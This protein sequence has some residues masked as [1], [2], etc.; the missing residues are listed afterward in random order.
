[1]SRSS[2]AGRFK[3]YVLAESS[4]DWKRRGSPKDD[5]YGLFFASSIARNR[6]NAQ[7]WLQC[8]NRTTK[9]VFVDESAA[10]DAAGKDENKHLRLYSFPDIYR[11]ANPL[12]DSSVYRGA[13]HAMQQSMRD[14]LTTVESMEAPV[15]L[16]SDHRI[17]RVRKKSIKKSTMQQNAKS[18][19]PAKTPRSNQK[20]K[21]G[22]ST[23]A[24]ATNAND[25]VPNPTRIFEEPRGRQLMRSQRSA[26]Q[27]PATKLTATQG[28]VSVSS[29]AISSQA[30]KPRNSTNAT[31]ATQSIAT[32]T[33]LTND[34]EDALFRQ[35]W[36]DN[37]LSDA[38]DTLDQQGID[39]QRRRE[40]DNDKRQKEIDEQWRLWKQKY[41]DLQA[42]RLAREQ[43]RLRV[44]DDRK[45]RRQQQLEEVAEQRRKEEERQQLMEQER[46]LEA[47]RI[48]LEEIANLR[49]LARES[50]ENL[51]PGVDLLG[52]SVAMMEL[53][54]V[55]FAQQ[56]L[57]LFVSES[58][59]LSERELSSCP[60]VNPWTYENNSCCI[61]VVLMLALAAG[62][63][64]NKL[65]AQLLSEDKR[66]DSL[67]DLAAKEQRLLLREALRTEDEA[68]RCKTALRSCTRVR[69]RLADCFSN[70]RSVISDGEFQDAHE[71]LDILLTALVGQRHVVCEETHRLVDAA[72]ADS[73][74]EKTLCHMQ[75]TSVFPVFHARALQRCEERDDF[76]QSVLRAYDGERVGRQSL[77]RLLYR[78]NDFSPSTR[79]GD[80]SVP[81]RVR[82]ALL[83]K[84]D[85]TKHSVPF[86]Y[87]FVYLNRRRERN[88]IH[89]PVVF[90]RVLALPALQNEHP[91]SSSAQPLLGSALCCTESFVLAGIACF[92]KAHWTLAFRTDSPSWS[93]K[94]SALEPD[95][96][97]GDTTTRWL[98]YDDL[99][100]QQTG[101]NSMQPIGNTYSD[102]LSWGPDKRS[103]EFLQKT[104]SLFLYIKPTMNTD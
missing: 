57:S 100:S 74:E 22:D 2:R 32:E 59:T 7:L 37:W 95:D 61:D 70:K 24:S 55:F 87:V 16:W 63:N 46:Q 26:A 36:R 72:V 19:Q 45:R 3:W 25:T 27:R 18:T 84:S 56:D 76:N 85:L 23:H 50:R 5:G 44:A 96:F 101:S 78:D 8:F 69:D 77:Q 62:G 12:R 39:L 91:L 15:P 65:R 98:Y 68:I 60:V 29:Q 34:V 89:A 31:I 82:R 47:Q 94:F 33:S 6:A 54:R 97:D 67:S 49:R 14:S 71:V 52:Q 102:L 90:E 30:K 92:H 75:A 73:Q 35:R 41:A 88:V 64:G 83:Q 42:Q 13:F 28:V 104:G 99:Q 43:Q 93:E 21:R 66:Y 86:E 38:I 11:S 79:I 80:S 9:C 17:V 1:M 48:A 103:A 10:K 81:T 58:D 20:R 4:A 53:E 40:K 51:P